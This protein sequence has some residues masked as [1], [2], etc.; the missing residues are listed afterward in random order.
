M[1]MT[2]WNYQGSVITIDDVVITEPILAYL[3]FVIWIL[4]EIMSVYQIKISHLQ[5]I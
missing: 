3:Q 4:Q 1:A 5:Y 2:I